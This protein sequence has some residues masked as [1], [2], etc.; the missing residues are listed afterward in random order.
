MEVTERGYRVIA[1]R[2]VRYPGPLVVRA[3]EE[4]R[5]GERDT[6]WPYRGCVSRQGRGAG[7]PTHTY[8]AISHDLKTPVTVLLGQAQLLQRRDARGTLD[9]EGLRQGLEHIAARSRMLADLV[10]ELQDVTRLRIGEDLLLDRRPV[11][12]GALVQEVVGGLDEDA[13][14]HR[15]VV[16][17]DG[18][19]LVGWWD[20][21]RLRR[22]MDNLLGNALKY[23][24]EGSDVVVTVAAELTPHGESA[25]LEV[26]DHGIGIAE[27]DLPHIFELFYRGKN[28]VQTVD[29]MG[30]GLPGSRHIVEQHGGTI[31]AESQEGAGSVFT[32]RL[33]LASPIIVR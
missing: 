11:D 25:V 28:G 3:D 12:L 24:P 22:V 14:G 33:L 1:A 19:P 26:R 6:R 18:I 21:V 2:Q 29:G 9:E 16:K 20:R 5:V 10:D 15:I 32:V 31:T 4:V 13:T 30:I 7:H 17:A 23:S 27:D 8:P